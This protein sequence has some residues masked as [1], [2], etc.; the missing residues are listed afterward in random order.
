MTTPNKQRAGA[1]KC[2]LCLM[3]RGDSH[4][5]FESSVSGHMG[6]ILEKQSTNSTAL[7]SDRVWIRDMWLDPYVDDVDWHISALQTKNK[8]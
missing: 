1:V 5:S 8:V 7:G 3:V 2:L 4:S 6:A